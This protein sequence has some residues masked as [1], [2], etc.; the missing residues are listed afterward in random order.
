MEFGQV[1]F[2]DV[3][4]PGARGSDDDRLALALLEHR[5]GTEMGAPANCPRSRGVFSLDLGEEAMAFCNFTV[6]N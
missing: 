4:L 5:C 3:A 2:Q 1:S 6:D